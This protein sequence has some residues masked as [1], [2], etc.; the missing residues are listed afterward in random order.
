[1]VVSENA[2]LS[3]FLYLTQSTVPEKIEEGQASDSRVTAFLTAFKSR[4]TLNKKIFPV[5]KIPKS[6]LTIEDSVSSESYLLESEAEQLFR[7]FEHVLNQSL[8]FS[9]PKKGPKREKYD[10]LKTTLFELQSLNAHVSL[11]V[12][13]SDGAF[14]CHV[15]RVLR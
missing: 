10:G 3:L 15:H 1:M 7:L 2:R 6:I 8:D 11:L 14:Q 13:L 4:A 9:L 12:G 5:E